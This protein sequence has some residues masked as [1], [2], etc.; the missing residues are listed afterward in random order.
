[1]RYREIPSSPRMF[2]C[3]SVSREN[4]IASRSAPN[5]TGQP[6]QSSCAATDFG[7][8]M[9]D[10]DLQRRDGHRAD[11]PGDRDGARQRRLVRQPHAE[12]PFAGAVQ[13]EERAARIRAQLVFHHAGPE[14]GIAL[15]PRVGPA[16]R[17]RRLER[18]SQRAVLVEPHGGTVAHRQIGRRRSARRSAPA[19]R[20]RCRRGSSPSDPRR[21]RDRGRPRSEARAHRR[22]PLPRPPSCARTVT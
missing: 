10:E 9:P 18:Q 19:G 20:N 7:A 3:A 13:D 15:D 11:L 4:R 5:R 21:R 12:P 1:M 22:P 16:E 17:R 8:R 14:P 2:G 6:N